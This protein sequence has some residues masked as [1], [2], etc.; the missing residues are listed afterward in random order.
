MPNTLLATFVFGG[1]LVGG[2][3]GTFWPALVQSLD[4]DNE[5]TVA[6]SSQQLWSVRISN[7]VMFLM[8]CAG[9]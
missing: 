3:T 1:M 5:S 7:A 2:F 4:S 8:G 6:P 9:I